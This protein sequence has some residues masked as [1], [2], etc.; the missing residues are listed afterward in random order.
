MR[1]ALVL[2]CL[3]LFPKAIAAQGPNP[4]APQPQAG[5]QPPAAQPQ[6]IELSCSDVALRLLLTNPDG[7]KFT[8]PPGPLGNSV[9]KVVVFYPEAGSHNE[10]AI[11]EIISL[12]KQAKNGT[13]VPPAQ[14]LAQMQTQQSQAAAQNN[15]AMGN[16][17]NPQTQPGSNRQDNLMLGGNNS[18]FDF[19]APGTGGNSVMEP[20]ADPNANR[21]PA[22]GIPER[23]PADQFP[24]NNTQSQNSLPAYHSQLPNLQTGGSPM[25]G[26]NQR[27][28][29]ALN[30]MP[31]FGVVPA[32]Q[33]TGNL[34]LDRLINRVQALNDQLDYQS[35]RVS[36][37]QQD[38]Y[39]L[40]NDRAA[41]QLATRDEPFGS[42]G[43]SLAGLP[44][45]NAAGQ[46]GNRTNAGQS[47][48]ASL[49]QPANIPG[50]EV[51]RRTDDARFMLLWLFLAG[52]IGLNIYLGMI[53]R[54]LYVRYAD[55]ADELRETFSTGG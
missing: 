46:F 44:D 48:P 22:P 35:T 33:S 14:R 23:R 7:I 55:L 40:R 15:V 12:L 52:S 17:A 18:R 50:P 21:I 13:Y 51:A 16:P 30:G 34:M 4:G 38:N 42:A 29:T 39:N 26:I 31:E 10:Q 32:G 3:S 47:R 2:I 1:L 6:D 8:P 54:G 28:G 49:G 25:V 27:P 19:G 45:P 9:N 43:T 24:M 37:L 5:Q 20:Q 11:D 53:A 36:Q 41:G